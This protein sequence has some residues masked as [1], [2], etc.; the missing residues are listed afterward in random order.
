M[1]ASSHGKLISPPATSSAVAAVMR[2]NKKRDTGPEMIVRRFLFSRGYRY[3]VH[4]CELPGHPDIVFATRRKVIFVHGCFWHQ[5]KSADCPLY[6]HPRS[7]L[8]YWK[9]KLRRNRERDVRNEA[10]LHKLGW[11][12]MVVWECEIKDISR[13]AKHLEKFLGRNGGKKRL[14]GMLSPWQRC[15]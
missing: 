10:A 1:S 5:H 6:S 12:I 13:L 15:A 14:H 3:R 2:A 8:D 9:P 11:Q 7:N 4:A